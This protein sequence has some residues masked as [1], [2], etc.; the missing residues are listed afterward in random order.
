MV[1][2]NRRKFL[3]YGSAALGSSLLLKA[4]STS[5][6]A[7]S[8]QPIVLGS[9]LDATGAIGAVGVQM[10]AA[11]ELAV[12]EINAAGGLLGRPV[13]LKQYDTQSDIQK[14]TQFAQQLILQDKVDV[15]MG[16]I[17]SAS[18]E[19]IRP[20]VN[21][22]QTLYFYNTQYEGGVCDKYTF[23]TGVTPSAQ[24]DKLIDYAANELN[25][26]TVYTIA[27]DYNYGQISAKWVKFYSQKYGT[28]VVQE[29]FI[30]LDVSDFS[31]IISKIQ[32]ANPDVVMSLLVGSNH[33]GFFG[34]WAGAGMQD[35][36]PI[37]AATFVQAYD[38]DGQKRPERAGVIASHSYWHDEPAPENQQFVSKFQDKF[39]TNK[40]LN[41]L[42]ADTYTGIMMWAEAVKQAESIEREAVTE[43]LESGMVYSSGPLGAVSFDKTHHINHSIYILKATD[44]QAFELAAGP[45][46]NIAATDDQG[47]CDL[48]TNPD[49]FEQFIPDIK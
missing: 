13:E 4:C 21:K 45:F 20:V 9:L 38:Q 22:Y 11:T 3:T 34:Q 27:A 15:L 32:Q 37:I 14:Y 7:G 44:T 19:A 42:G 33:E 1:M 10:I 47:K 28:T 48:L 49:T 18:R 36:I 8:N 12:E 31:T 41:F 46:K 23:C 24:L 17:T 16:G 5:G 26:K 40:Y 6:S 25:A 35:Q 39:G 30:P 43:V 2:L 29:D